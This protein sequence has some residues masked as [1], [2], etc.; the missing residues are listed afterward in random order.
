[1]VT[2]AGW[3]DIWLNEGFASYSELVAIEAL[4]TPE[5]AKEWVSNTMGSAKYG[6]SVFVTDSLNVGRLFSGPSTYKKGAI[7]LRMLRY[8]INNDSIFF[9][10]IRNYL[11]AHSYRN[12]FASDFKSMMEQTS[13][14]NLTLFFNQWYYNEGHPVLSGQWDQG[15]DGKIKLQ[16]SQVASKG[17]T[18]FVT[19]IDITFKYSGGD[20]TMRIMLDAVN[21]SYVFNLTGKTVYSVRIDKDDY[22]LNEMISLA[23]NPALGLSQY[24]E[25]AEVIVYPN[26]A[27]NQF[28]IANAEGS[29]LQITDVAGRQV[30][31]HKVNEANAIVDISQLPKGIYL[32]KVSRNANTSFTKLIKN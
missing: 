18:V 9:L 12:A 32:I 30:E 2:C 27:S 22:V 29:T 7:L 5:V 23:R 8:E 16:L 3:S 1:M 26:P 10:G 20:T 14:K 24:S 13:G 4:Q 6:S 21:K 31:M 15:A 11:K 25:F 17:N 19:P 28:T